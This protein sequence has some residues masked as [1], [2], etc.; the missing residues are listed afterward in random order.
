MKKKVI[1]IAAV[2][3]AL[4]CVTGCSR[5][6]EDVAKWEIQGNADKLTEALTDPK[7]EVRKAAAESLGTL[8]AADAVD[9]LAACLNDAENQ[10]RLAAIDALIAIGTPDAVTPLAA[11]F[12]LDDQQARLKAA[13]GLGALKATAA[14]DTLAEGLNDS[15]ETIQI[16]A[17]E[18][19]GEI[20]SKLGSKPLAE[21]LA[22]GSTSMKVKVACIDALART[23]GDDALAALVEALADTNESISEQATTALIT[24]G[25]PAIPAVIDG[26]K[27]SN[28]KV[29]S[30]SIK[31][32][33]GLGGIPTRGSG[34]V[35][36]QLAR[37][38]LSDDPVIK[39]ESVAALAE[40]GEAVVS[41]LIA[42][43]SLDVPEIREPAAQAL[44][45]IGEPAL[46]A[47]LEASEKVVLFEIREWY[48]GRADWIGAP[49][50]L[51]DLY[52]AVSI[53]NPD[54]PKVEDART[55]L[56]LKKGA[57]E[58]AHIPT[59]IKLL[60][61]D[62]SR[63]QAA[64]QLKAAGPTASLPLIA[65][66]TSTD[67]AIAE[68]AAALIDERKDMRALQPLMNAVQT[69][70]DAGESLSRSPLYSALVNLDQ[71]ETDPVVVKVRPNTA[72][73]IQVFSR[74]YRTAKVTAAVT[75]DS[76]MDNE[77]P[78]VFNIGYEE[79]GHSGT[80]EVTFKK[81]GKGNWHPSPALPY[82]LPKP[83]QAAP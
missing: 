25:R 21:A 76:Y 50:P 29:R 74:Q 54:F 34:L 12:K 75:T 72:R 30:A 14:I 77:A 28:P 69:R 41:E 46:D 37:A 66:I 47:I 51:I 45:L 60:G 79:D 80:L 10:V 48:K 39:A 52:A 2:M 35:W 62:E 53:L 70:T 6:V 17:C 22:K 31:L 82:A 57:P 63:Q 18:A 33:R 64:A 71:L 27:N 32:L 3:V 65:A 26:L 68:A 81:D 44:E 59:L 40:K 56:Y 38:S 1:S 67:T 11:A 55:I 4:L 13:A 83:K 61:E 5:T 42:G 49:S 43:A 24:I 7:F 16:A 23:G 58:R 15:D 78:I 36:Y 20:E 19:I 73:A 9:E 8:K